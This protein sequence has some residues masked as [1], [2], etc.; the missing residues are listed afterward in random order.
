M[1]TTL[2]AD[3][4]ALFADGCMVRTLVVVWVPR[5]AGELERAAREGVLV[6]RRRFE[7]K[8]ELPAAGKNEDVAV[9]VASLTVDGGL[10]VYGLDEDEHERPSIPTPIDLEGAAE[11]IDQVVGALVDEPPY[12]EVEPLR[13]EDDPG[14][15]Y[16]VVIVPPSPRA[17]HQVA[18][19]GDRRFYGRGDKG[20]RIL[21][22]GEVAR[23]YQ[24][25]GHWEVNER[26]LLDECIARSDH[27][28]QTDELG[29]LHGFA[30]PVVPDEGIWERALDRHG[31]ERDLLARLLQAARSVT[32]KTPYSPAWS[33]AHNWRELGADGWTLDTLTASGIDDPQYQVRADVGIDGSG[34]MFCGRAA[35]PPHRHLAEGAPRQLAILEVPIAANFA[36]FLAML[37]A[38]YEDAGYVGPVVYGMAVTGI[39]GAV[40]AAILS[41]IRWSGTPFKKESFERTA[42][43]ASAAQLLEPEQVT[44]ALMRRFLDTVRRKNYDPFTE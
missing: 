29:F 9:Q 38:L 34:Y 13:L 11:R 41:N 7:A 35:V 26:E 6:E 22:E 16:L 20:K 44:L 15:G 24:R 1:S 25:R 3:H 19:K 4:D 36:G 28:R 43:V 31:S 5:T 14:K 40:S 37:A 23:L 42:R 10:L 39:E 12:V 30:Q 27:G 17:P 18:V 21:S 2:R 33:E 8:R 32:T